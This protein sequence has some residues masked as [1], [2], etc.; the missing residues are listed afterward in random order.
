MLSFRLFGFQV[1]IEWMFWLLCV[2]LGMPFLQQDGPKALGQFLMITAIVLGSILWH[3]LGHAWARKYF[4]AP[5][6]E[7]LLYGFGGL[8][9]GPGPSGRGR[10]TRWESVI[11]AAAGPAASLLLGGL[12]ALIL[13][14]P[15]MQDPWVRFFVGQMLW[16]NVG[17]AILNLLP[18]LPLDGGHIF[19]GLT[20][21]RHRSIVPKVGFVLAL[22]MAAVGLLIF[23]SFFT[24]V[25]FGLLAHGNWQ[26]MKGLGTG[27]F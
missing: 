1:R 11:I 20:P 23:Q 14:T 26:R 18:I 9:S 27:H 3:E 19:S 8:C 15:G 4:R 5:W 25:M 7:I 6:S 21:D 16:V 10:F 13:F 12:T 17:W 2:L 22:V 24:A